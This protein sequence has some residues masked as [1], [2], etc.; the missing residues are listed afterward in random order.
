L[1]AEEVTLHGIKVFNVI[2]PLYVL[3]L[4]TGDSNCS[5]NVLKVQETLLSLAA[6]L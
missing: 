6:A 5:G 4:G 2:D 1:E 3:Y